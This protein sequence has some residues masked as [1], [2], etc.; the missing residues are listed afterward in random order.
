VL[1]RCDV[2]AHPS[3]AEGFPNAVLE[4]MCAAR[5][6]VA[7]RV[8]GI[9]EVMEDRVHGLLVTPQRPAEL[10]SALETLLQNPLAAHIMG[11]RGRQHVE[12]LYSLDKMCAA[13]ERL[14]ETL[15][16]GDLTYAPAP[17]VDA[18]AALG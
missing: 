5:P 16:G 9:P 15:V 7:T 12:N 14:Y 6:V 4:A 8:G 17:A 18:G 3:W 1:A 11:L 2:V 13:I 10:A